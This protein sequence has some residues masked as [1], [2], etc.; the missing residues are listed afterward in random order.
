MLVNFGSQGIF[1]HDGGSIYLVPRIC[2]T[3]VFGPGVDLLFPRSPPPSLSSC[4]PPPPHA[5]HS[6]PHPLH[7][8]SSSS[9]SS[10]FITQSKGERKTRKVLKTRKFNKIRGKFI[11]VGEVKNIANRG[12]VSF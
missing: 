9:L 7:S 6:S 5:P 4:P 1:L 3:G 10:H 2:S 11:E 8:H 12:K